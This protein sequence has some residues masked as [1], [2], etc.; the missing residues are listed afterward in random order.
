VEAPLGTAARPR[1]PLES[2]TS[3]STV[4]LPRLSMIS[5]ACTSMMVDMAF[6]SSGVEVR[7][8]I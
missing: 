1:A 3:A 2:T 7:R 4:G 6:R 8:R 5:R